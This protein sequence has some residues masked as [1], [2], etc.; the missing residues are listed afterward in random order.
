MTKTLYVGNLSPDVSED[1]L[2]ELFSGDG[3]EVESVKLATYARN[4]KSRGFGFVDM[5]S[6][7][8]AAAAL[9]AL[10]GADVS[11]RE[12]K[13]GEARRDKN[14]PPPSS[15]YEDDYGGGGGRFGS[16]GGSRRGR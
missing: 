2:R 13:I 4:G 7:E 12:L 3:R 8:Q 1:R 10:Q 14:A 5:A 15:S 6:E 9:T 16:R 11:G